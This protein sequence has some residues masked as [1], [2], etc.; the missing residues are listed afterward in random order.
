MSGSDGYGDEMGIEDHG[1]SIEEADQLLAG[2]TPAGRDDLGALATSLGSLSAAFHHE[3]DPVELR[4]WAGQ[5]AANAGLTPS[6]KGDLAATPASNANRPA[7]QA[8]GLPKRRIPVLS[9]IAA[10]VATTAGKTMVAGA[11]VAASTGGLA[12]T[13]N[14]P[15]QSDDA[16]VTVV[17]S[18]ATD[19]NDDV[20]ADDSDD[21]LDDLSDDVADTDEDADDDADETACEVEVEDD[22]DHDDDSDDD[23]DT[24]TDTDGC[25]TEDSD[26]ATEVEDAEVDEPAEVQE[27][28]EAP[29]ADEVDSPD[30]EDEADSPDED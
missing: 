4:K 10:F 15:G 14:L 28:D 16:V 11:L 22:A 9:S 27:A 13:G 12:A 7:P 26:E 6:D 24:D 2:H 18:S 5:A 25:E 21:S 20:V 8:S 17:D 3:V 30:S 1:L 23:A 29:E 19:A